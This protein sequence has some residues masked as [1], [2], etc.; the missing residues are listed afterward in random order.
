MSNLPT[1][2]IIGG[3]NAD[4]QY[5]EYLGKGEFRLSRCAACQTWLWPAHFRCGECGS[6]EIEW[7]EL[8]ATGAVYSWTRTWYSFDRTKE[9]ADDIPYVTVLTEVDDAGGA[10]VL[11]MLE[12][13]ESN[14][15]IGAKVHGVVKAPSEKSKHYP[16]ICWVLD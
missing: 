4:E 5:W 9:R 12:G 7:V 14:L 13:D 2:R 16:S 11:G 10:R 3:I 6:W 15:A 1:D 8:P